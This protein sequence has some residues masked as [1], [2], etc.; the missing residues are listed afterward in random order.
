M[1]DFF[2]TGEDR[3][4]RDEIRDFLNR[5]L[6]PRAE[7]IERDEDRETVKEVVRAIG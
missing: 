6:A 3:A 4:F 2:P 7:K 5:E 1:R